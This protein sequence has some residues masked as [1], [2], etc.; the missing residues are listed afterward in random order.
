MK[1]I[2][3]KFGYLFCLTIV[4]AMIGCGNSYG[5]NISDPDEIVPSKVNLVE[6]LEG[7]D[8]TIT[9]HTSIDGSDLILDRVIA[10]KGSTFIDITYGLTSEDAKT[11]F[12]VYCKIYDDDYYILAR[13]GN[14]VYCVSDKKTFSK[15]GFSSTANI[16]E[17]YIND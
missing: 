8:Y 6:N 10:K 5:T 1:R 7:D 2:L 13:N 12:G 17:Q 3:K 14:Y 11:I 9:E 4:L 16:G 15:A